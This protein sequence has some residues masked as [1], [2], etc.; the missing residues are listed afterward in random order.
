MTA[1]RVAALPEPL[2]HGWGTGATASLAAVEAR[3][4]L[5]HP[6]YL[7]VLGYGVLV[8]GIDFTHGFAN[9]TRGDV[10]E[11]LAILFVVFLPLNAVLAAS[12]V[13]TS[14][15]RAGSEETFGALPVTGRGR[16]LALLLAG[17]GPAAVGGLVAATVWYLQ[18]DL[19]QPSMELS[20]GALAATPLLYLGTTALAVAAAR[21]LP[22]PGVALVLVVGLFVWVSSTHGSSHAAAVLTAPWIVDPDTDKVAVIAGYSN[23]W[24]FVYL[25]GLVGLAA[26]AAL[27]RDDLRRMIAVGIAIGL[28][29]LFAA[30]AQLP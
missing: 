11:F 6:V 12:L 17:S 18:K 2:T 28:P 5:T 20:G 13:A 24:H 3:R 4:F 14:A 30:W 9:V 26:T 25:S 21:W 27:F 23:V 10:A 22:W 15:R 7:V 1:A 16:T 19:V 29:T 8:T